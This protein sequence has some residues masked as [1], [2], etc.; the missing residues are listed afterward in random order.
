M[1][2]Y[3]RQWRM[4]SSVVKAPTGWLSLCRTPHWTSGPESQYWFLQSTASV[5]SKKKRKK[6]KPFPFCKKSFLGQ[7]QKGVEHLTHTK[8][9]SERSDPICSRLDDISAF[10]Q[11]KVMKL[12]IL[13]A[14]V[15]FCLQILNNNQVVSVLDFLS[16]V[17]SAGLI[18][19]SH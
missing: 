4:A 12:L 16:P 1:C 5:D 11:E 17:S 15:C 6:K 7:W 3:N 10:L 19:T 8:G 2:T 9:I 13:K 14:K 18:Y